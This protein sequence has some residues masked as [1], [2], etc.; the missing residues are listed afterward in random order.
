MD[1]HERPYK[2]QEKL[3]EHLQGFTYSGGLI[4]HNKEV[5][6][7]TGKN[8]IFCTAQDCK[9]RTRPFTQKGNL[10][11]HVRRV[12]SSTVSHQGL[13]TEEATSTLMDEVEQLKANNQRKTEHIE[14]LERELEEL[15][16]TASR[17]E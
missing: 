7:G 14:R 5:H 6:L 1:K 17:N 11:E 9:R 4:R 3:C 12:H 15:K 16:R 10:Q 2:C 13:S 8:E